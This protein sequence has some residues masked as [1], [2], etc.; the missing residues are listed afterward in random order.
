MTTYMEP[1]PASASPSKVSV[2]TSPVSKSTQ[3]KL[4]LVIPVTTT[5]EE[6]IGYNTKF[7]T[8][9]ADSPPELVTVARTL[10]APYPVLI[11]HLTSRIQSLSP[12]TT[13]FNVSKESR[14]IKIAT[15]PHKTILDGVKKING[16]CFS[17]QDS[18]EHDPE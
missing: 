9:F 15:G 13:Y 10:S 4:R 11:T 6:I 18:T 1:A 5:N 14:I 8:L 3:G 17:G 7:I 2:Q 16:R 12:L